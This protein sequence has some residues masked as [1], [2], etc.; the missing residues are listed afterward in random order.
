[1]H[2]AGGITFGERRDEHLIS[3]SP[4]NWRSI[5]GVERSVMEDESY[6]KVAA[7]L[8]GRCESFRSKH[9]FPFSLFILG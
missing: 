4:Y 6:R 8:S 2:L 9:H 3:S 7:D 1:M 5:Q